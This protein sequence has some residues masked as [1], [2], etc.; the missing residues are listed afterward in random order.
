MRFRFLL[1]QRNVIAYT[2]KSVAMRTFCEFRSHINCRPAIVEMLP[3]M[4]MT[5]F[6]RPARSQTIV[7]AP[8]DFLSHPKNTQECSRLKGVKAT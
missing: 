4:L 8:S 1:R 7:E 3:Q 2:H 5:Q 6:L